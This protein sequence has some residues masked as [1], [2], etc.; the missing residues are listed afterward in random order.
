MCTLVRDDGTH[1]HTRKHI[2]TATGLTSIA[3]RCWTNGLPSTHRRGSS[4]GLTLK[5]CGC[6]FLD[7]NQV[8]CFDVHMRCMIGRVCVC[9]CHR[10]QRAGHVQLI[11]LPTPS[12]H[13][14]SRQFE[15]FVSF[16]NR[17]LHQTK[18]HMKCNRSGNTHYISL[19]NDVRRGA[20]E[21][22]ISY[23]R[24]ELRFRPSNCSQFI[25][26]GSKCLHLDQKGLNC[27]VFK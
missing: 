2:H 22:F 18:L 20:A 25:L 1:T 3:W 4:T 7:V 12:S 6:M 16:T 15:M 8:H 9:V 24:T 5:A 19:Y 10:R 14:I 17:K 11:P 13:Q 27:L 23:I 21:K 26:F